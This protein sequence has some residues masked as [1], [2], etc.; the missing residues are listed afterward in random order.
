MTEPRRLLTLAA[1]LN[2]IL[3]A[4]LASAQTVV[5]RNAAPE[6][7]V[8]V[9]LN[10]KVVGSGKAN[11]GGY[12]IVVANLSENLKKT[13]IDAQIF[14]DVCDNVRRVLIV[15]RG[16]TPPPAEATCLRRDMS[17]LFL[18]QQISSIVVDVG[19]PNPTLLL[20]QGK[21]SLTPKKVWSDL[22]KGLIV[23][24]GGNLSKYRDAPRF[25]CGDA[26]DCSG[27]GWGFG[28]TAGADFWVTPWL[29]AEGAYF[30]P[31]NL[32]IDGSGS[33]YSFTHSLKADIYTVAG[34]VGIP[35]RRA[36]PYGKVGANFIQTKS[37]TTNTL[38]D[39]SVT[40]DGVVTTIPGGTE[41]Y[42]IKT[43]GWSWFLA[44][45]V[46]AWF[47]DR[48]AMYGEFGR[49]VLKGDTLQN[50]EGDFDDRKTYFVVGMRVH[51]K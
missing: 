29:A 12:A 27:G 31:G 49:M 34:K 47:S 43:E 38:K 30:K 26:T 51:I 22:P 16:G 15:E 3:G 17:G 6:T 50:V 41:N 37:E 14:V 45:G 25:Q 4:G 8:E 7:P 1:A 9:V 28:F 10:D 11:S 44:G 46:E 24:G 19:G 33:T 36:R 35:A 2:L 32:N 21:V 40:I 20:R 39:R 42:G 23:F 5:V 48:I 13:E 18:V